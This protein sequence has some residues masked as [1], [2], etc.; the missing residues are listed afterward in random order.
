MSLQEEIKALYERVCIELPRN[1]LF[2]DDFEQAFQALSEIVEY[3]DG[4]EHIDYI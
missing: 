1:S 3:H 4:G 2:D